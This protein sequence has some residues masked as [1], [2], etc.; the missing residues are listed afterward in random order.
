MIA[1]REELGEIDEIEDFTQ[2]CGLT[3]TDQKQ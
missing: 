3:E 2:V 1:V